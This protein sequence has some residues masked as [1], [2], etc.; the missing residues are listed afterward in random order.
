MHLPSVEALRD[1]RLDPGFVE[2]LE[3]HVASCAACGAENRRLELVSSLL[4]ALPDPEMNPF[5]VARGR[6]ALLDAA[7]LRGDEGLRARRR[8][9]ALVAL[10]AALTVGAVVGSRVA[11]LG[12]GGHAPAFS[13][14]AAARAA[15]AWTVTVTASPG[16]HWSRAATAAGERVTLLEGRLDIGVEGH[17]AGHR[18][19][20]ALPDG[21]LEDDGTVFSVNVAGAKTTAVSV[22]A[23]SV[24]LR[25]KGR[26]ERRL[27][28]GESFLDEGAHGAAPAKP[29][30]GAATGRTPAESGTPT[31]ERSVPPLEQ[32]LAP[33]SASARPKTRALTDA[34]ACPDVPRFEDCV[35][36]FKRGEY[37]AAAAAF[38]RYSA[39]CARHAEDATYLQMVALARAG[40]TSEARAVAHSYLERFPAGFRHQEAEV[41]ANA[42]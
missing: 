38:S 42:H 6:R 31:D 25:L 3:R 19:V 17:D 37:A 11:G 30:D 5:Q 24:T 21:E 15:Q 26:A 20:V 40:H 9:W 29:L 7:N 2:E 10:G 32:R 39:G 23:G 34:E 33:S 18:L 12:F 27:S 36:T 16:A 8:S 1:G 4:R 22:T 41:I 14:P 35:A 13:S 28:A